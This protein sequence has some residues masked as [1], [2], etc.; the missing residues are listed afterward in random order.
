MPV[1][2][3]KL[4]RALDPELS[5]IHYLLHV[6]KDRFRRLLTIHDVWRILTREALDWAFIEGFVDK[7]GLVVPVGQTLGA[8]AEMLEVDLPQAAAGIARGGHRI[9]RFIWNRLWPE[10]IRLLGGVGVEK[11]RR[12]QFWLPFL[13]DG[14]FGDALR[15][16]VCRLLPPRPV[17]DWSYPGVAGPY[18]WKLVVGRLLTGRRRRQEIRWREIGRGDRAEDEVVD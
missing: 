9:R 8:V 12:R 17:V 1:S 7:E 16:W 4:V 3:C 5:L 10:S 14:R 15:F 11:H 2:D 18:P 13:I 6:N